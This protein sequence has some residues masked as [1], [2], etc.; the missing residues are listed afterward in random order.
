MHNPLRST[1]EFAIATQ[2]TLK[3]GLELLM[4]AATIFCGAAIALGFRFEKPG[5]R[6]ESLE[7][8]YTTL[9][10]RVTQL[11]TGRKDIVTAIGTIERILCL[12]TTRRDADLAGAC[13]TY[14]TLDESTRVVR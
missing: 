5:A 12:K 2:P 6:I 11:E 3:R 7:T 9:D 1:A 4:L 13:K 14:P 10:A 8:N